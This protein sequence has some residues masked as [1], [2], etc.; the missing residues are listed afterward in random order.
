METTTQISYFSPHFLPLILPFFD[1]SCL[2]QLL[3]WNLPN[4]DFL[5]LS[6]LPHLLVEIFLQVR[7]IPSPP[8]VYLPNDLYQYRL[9]GIYFILWVNSIIYFVVDVFSYEN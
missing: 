5:L 8:L 7:A 9:M 6:L 1:G 2:Q 4:G 3:L